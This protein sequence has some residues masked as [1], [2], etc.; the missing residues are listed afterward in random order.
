MMERIDMYSLAGFLTGI[1]MI[2]LLIFLRFA[3]IKK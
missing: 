1:F 2:F 3:K